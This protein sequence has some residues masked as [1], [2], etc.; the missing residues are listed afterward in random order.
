MSS[1]LKWAGA[2]TRCMEQL[3]NSLPSEHEVECFVEP[4]VGS[5]S[6]FLNTCYRQYVL[7]DNNADLIDVYRYARDNPSRLISNLKQLWGSGHNENIYQENRKIFNS[8]AP[9]PEKSALFIWL[10]RH[11][12]NGICRYNKK[13]QFNVPYGRPGNCR[14]PEHDIFNFVRKTERCH[15]T[16]FH[17]DF[18]ETLKIV[19]EGMFS[20]LRCAVYCDPPYLPLNATSGFTAYTGEGFPL[21]SHLQLA[22]TLVRLHTRTGTPVIV[23]AS[24]TPLSR[25]VYR[26]FTFKELDVRRSV[27]ASHHSRINAP[28]IICSLR[29]VC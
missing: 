4:F 23:S 16:F 2:K 6:V 1:F 3:L 17:A 12:F 5:A 14:L 18:E 28:E 27:S 19:T 13:G 7:A 22:G 8:L 21:Q 9:G 29:T 15:V 10:N 20:S 26:S 24:D 11:G 25:E